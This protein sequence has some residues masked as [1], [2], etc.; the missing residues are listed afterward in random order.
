MT[1]RRWCRRCGDKFEVF[2]KGYAKI[3]PRCVAISRERVSLAQWH[4]FHPGVPR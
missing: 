3:C 2:G 1:W 4:K